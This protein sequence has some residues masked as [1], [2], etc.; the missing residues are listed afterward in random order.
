MSLTREKSREI[1]TELVVCMHRGSDEDEER[2]PVLL[3]EITEQFE[4]QIAVV[5]EEAVGAF[6]AAIAT[7]VQKHPKLWRRRF[8]R[9]INLTEVIY[10]MDAEHE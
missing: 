5:A 9:F 10:R 2:I 4:P 7:D 3:G 8:Q 6:R 1:I